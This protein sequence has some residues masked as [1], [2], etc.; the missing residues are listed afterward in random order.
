MVQW[1]KPVSDELLRRQQAA[2]ERMGGEVAAGL[3]QVLRPVSFPPSLT[4]YTRP[5]AS[6]RAAPEVPRA[7]AVQGAD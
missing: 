2:L 6:E 7:L 4:G 5:Q 3:R 1:P